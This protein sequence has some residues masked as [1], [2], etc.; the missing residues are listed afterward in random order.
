MISNFDMRPLRTFSMMAFD[1]IFE[2]WTVFYDL[3][4]SCPSFD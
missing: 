2:L 1:S 3:R 4:L